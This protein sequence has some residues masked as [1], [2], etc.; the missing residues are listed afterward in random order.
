MGVD[1]LVVWPLIVC[2]MVAQG[3]SDSLNALPPEFEVRTTSIGGRKI[4]Y[5]LADVLITVERFWGF[6][7]E[8]KLVIVGAGPTVHYDSDTPQFKSLNAK[9][10]LAELTS[11][12]DSLD[13]CWLGLQE[14]SLDQLSVCKKTDPHRS[15]TEPELKIAVRVGEY[16]TCIRCGGVLYHKDEL[17]SDV[18]KFMNQVLHSP[19]VNKMVSEIG[20]RLSYKSPPPGRTAK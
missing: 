10:P 4:D 15:P 9:M 14:P 7:N 16:G 17:P 11:I 13:L 2:L 1:W 6:D 5:R 12:V 19:T 3:A 8:A 18:I 20:D